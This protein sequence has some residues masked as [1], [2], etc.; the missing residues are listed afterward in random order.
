MATHDLFRA[1]DT[2]SQLGIMKQGK[3]LENFSTQDLSLTE[4]EK[5]YLNQMRDS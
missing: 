1:Q 4:L 3:L 5:L 2:G